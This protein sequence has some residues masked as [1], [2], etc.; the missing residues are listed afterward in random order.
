MNLMNST[1]KVLNPGSRGYCNNYIYWISNID[2]DLIHRM[3]NAKEQYM[4]NK[5]GDDHVHI[6]SRGNV[7]WD[8][9]ENINPTGTTPFKF[10]PGY[11]GRGLKRWTITRYISYLW[12][13]INPVELD[14][15]KTQW[16]NVQKN[17][18]SQ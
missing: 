7:W 14:Q 16:K 3:M 11:R 1:L 2:K 15:I 13:K 9:V 4:R 5:L 8:Y 10:L 6:D 18:Q 17:I 12:S